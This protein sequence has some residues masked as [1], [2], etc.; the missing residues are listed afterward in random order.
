LATAQGQEA[1]E[2]VDDH[3]EC[4]PEPTYLDHCAV[5]FQVK[6][7]SSLQ[8]EVDPAQDVLNNLLGFAPAGSASDNLVFLTQ[9]LTYTLV[10]AA[11]AHGPSVNT[12][13]TGQI[14]DVIQAVARAESYPHALFLFLGFL[15]GQPVLSQLV[16]SRAANL[17]HTC[18]FLSV[19]VELCVD[20]LSHQE[21]EHQ[22]LSPTTEELD[23]WSLAQEHTE[24]E[25]ISLSGTA[26]NETVCCN[27]NPSNFLAAAR[28]AWVMLRPVG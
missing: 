16:I 27:T 25:S 12:L 14:E 18:E 5:S 10:V 2:A 3:E 22:P 7:A 28:M 9:A 6:Q 4:F 15:A 23:A 17:T 26:P 21:H 8:T 20:H 13:A 19:L 1:E 24:T 11:T